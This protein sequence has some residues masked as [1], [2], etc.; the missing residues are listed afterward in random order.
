VLSF[1]NELLREKDARIA[2][3]EAPQEGL[4]ELGAE[5]PEA[6]SPP[7]ETFTVNDSLEDIIDLNGPIA[8]GVLTWVGQR[9]PDFIEAWTNWKLLEEDLKPIYNEAGYPWELGAAQKFQESHVKAHAGSRRGAVGTDQFIRATGRK[10]GLRVVQGF[11]ERQDPVKSTRAQI[12][13]MQDLLK[14]FDGD[15][16]LALAAYNGASAYRAAM[17]ARRKNPKATFWDR[18]VYLSSRRETR[19]YVALV[20]AAA[21][22]LREPE[23]F[24][25]TEPAVDT[26]RAELEL[27]RDTT[28]DQLAFC[29]GDDPRAGSFGFFRA[30]R[31]MNP[32]YSV[33]D[34]L[35]KGT[36]LTVPAVAKERYVEHCIGGAAVELAA[37]LHEHAFPEYETYR[38]RR[39]DTLQKI[40][41]RYGVRWGDIARENGI[42]KP[43]VIHP[44]DVLIIPQD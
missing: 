4:E 23:R 9:R 16:S 42:K 28:I 26:R 10:Y 5:P 8:R 19:D 25:F 22:I 3:L 32:Q 2:E 31:N 43:Y 41:R 33:K 1:E 14:I 30:L 40:G 37:R 39:G 12:A 18:E 38:V 34:T 7:Q 29:L 13:Y 35:P 20:L 15:Y 24:G 21:M 44:G 6:I 36:T 27:A 11:D 17:R